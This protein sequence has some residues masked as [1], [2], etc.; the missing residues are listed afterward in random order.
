M[1]R[2]A[3]RA[4]A[5]AFLLLA[6][7]APEHP[8][9]MV[10]PVSEFG[11][12]Q[13]ALWATVTWW[14]VGIM[15]VVFGV[16]AYILVRFRAR[17]GAPEPKPVYGSTKLEIAWTV[18]PA[19]II[20]FIAIPTIQAIFDTQADPPEGALVV[21]AIGH[22]W[23]WE[24]RY[25]ELD[26]VTAN[27]FYVPVGRPLALRL[28]SADV[29]HSFWIPRFGGKKDVNPVPRTPEGVAPLHQNVISLTVDSAGEYLGQCAEFCGT[30]HAIMRMMAVAVEPEAFEAWVED[31]RSPVEPSGELASRGRDEFL[32]ST[33]VACH[34]IEGTRAQGALGPDLTLFGERFSIGA[35]LMANTEE[36]LT[37]WILHAPEL[38]KGILMPGSAVGAGGMPPTNLSREDAR[39]I[40]AYLSDLRR[41]MAGRRPAGARPEDPFL[42]A[43]AE[44]PE[45]LT[46]TPATGAPAGVP[47]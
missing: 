20:L 14:T 32:S 45:E 37:E 42:V 43:P 34:T 44:S 40:A 3:R 8:Q 28:R 10:E 25:P 39:A 16:L 23:W 1:S 41:P 9:T 47:R 33:C 15:V 7:C 31:M 13:T 38:K 17:E 18:I 35:G 2:I 21:E 24:F 12:I 30:S 46:D 19:L 11:R 6:G 5:G 26:V 36:N 29:I 22:Q 27:E 4:F